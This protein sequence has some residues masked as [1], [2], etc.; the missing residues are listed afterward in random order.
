MNLSFLS[1]LLYVLA[2]GQES[3]TLDTVLRDV[4]LAFPKLMATRLEAAVAK[5]KSQEKRGAFDPVFSF[6]TE[7]LRYNS[8]TDPGKA[9]TT[10]M[11]DAVIEVL[12]RSGVK[13]SVGAR[14]NRGDVKSPS[15]FTGGFGEYFVSAKIPLLRDR[16]N[17]AKT[18]AEQQAL[19]GEPIADQFIREAQLNLFKKAGTA[20]WELVGAKAK[21]EVA[22]QLLKLAADRAEYIRERIRKGANPPIDQQEADAEV[23]RRQGGLDK[24]ERD[25][26][27]AEIKLGLFRWNQD[28]STLEASRTQVRIQSL[29]DRGTK[30]EPLVAKTAATQD[31]PE[32]LAL[33]LSQQVLALDLGLAQNDRRPGLDLII[34]PGY[35]FG[36]DSI[37]NTMKAGVFYTIPLRQNSVDG[38]INAT[39]SKLQ[40]LGLEYKQLERSVQIE[41]D[42]ALSA[43]AQTEKRLLAAQAE[44]KGNQAVEDGERIK[45]VEG[46]STLF[47]INQ[48]ER[49]TAES[50]ARLI[51]VKVELQLANLA[52]LASTAQ[53]GGSTAGGARVGATPQGGAR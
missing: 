5:A 23:A 26:Q 3:L 7:F 15:S 35:D 30:V 18:V 50:Q 20:Y 39:K 52:F 38:R 27:K 9:K 8:S 4:D 14:L 45:F 49:A 16:I 46:L 24:A 22:Q 37:G 29:D 13:Y 19:L 42:D 48:R 53:L 11:S 43:L 36:A 28:G 25:V 10:S 41:V 33:R 6:D 34:G 51:D 12:D 40:K 47:L 31:R 44:V 21:L 17:N 32:L 1:A 2:P